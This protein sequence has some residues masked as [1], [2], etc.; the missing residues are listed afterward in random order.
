MSIKFMTA[1][2]TAAGLST[3]VYAANEHK[4]TEQK[5]KFGGIVKEVND[6][7][8]K[9]VAKSEVITVYADDHGKPADL[10]GATGKVTIRAG[11]DRKEVAL[12]HVDGN[13]LEAKGPFQLPVGTV[14]ILQVKRATAKAEDSTRFQLK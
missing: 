12:T 11:A 5:P 13:K 1:L 14:V 3:G 10:K 4:H 2:L 9:L 6:V 7:A 8:Y